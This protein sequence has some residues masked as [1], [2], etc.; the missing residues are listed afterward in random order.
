MTPEQ[1]TDMITGAVQAHTKNAVKAA[2]AGLNI[3][4]SI[5]KALGPLQEQIAKIGTPAAAA[6]DPKAH[7]AAENPE[8]LS[9]QKKFAD[10][11][12]AHNDRELELQREK[13]NARL[14]RTRI[15]LRSE[16]VKNNFTEESLDDVVDLA[17]H[18]KQVD[19]DEDGNAVFKLKTK[20]A[21]THPEEDHVFKLA[22]GVAHFAKTAGAQRYIKAPEAGA[23]KTVVGAR[24]PAVSV[25]VPPGGAS[26]A[27]GTG[28]PADR[29]ARMSD[30]L[31]QLTQQ[32]NT[33]GVTGALGGNP[34]GS[35]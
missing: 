3:N 2:L 16:L 34:F 32:A 7:K 35:G 9:L 33:L 26:G 4:D 18:R 30:R 5:A 23:K 10:L 12:K 25:T 28:S 6:A 11:E 14:D 1:I 31:T 13:E 17:F 27:V 21:P 24:A 29:A 8:F 15:A 19:F 20:L 22:D